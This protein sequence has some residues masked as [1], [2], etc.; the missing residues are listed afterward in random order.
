M[1]AAHACIVCIH[2]VP[3]VAASVNP[4][5]PP[6]QVVLL[7]DVRMSLDTCPEPHADPISLTN[8]RTQLTIT[9]DPAGPYRVWDCGLMPYR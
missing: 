1:P 7:N 5:I 8:R 6:L 3:L 4:A 2:D 9:S